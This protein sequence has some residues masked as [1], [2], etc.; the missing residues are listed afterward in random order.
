[1]RPAFPRP[2]DLEIGDTAGLETCGTPVSTK[3]V[4]QTSKSAVSR[5]AKP[6][7][8]P[9]IQCARHF[10]AQPIWKSAIQQ[11][12]K[13]AVRRS[14]PNPY[15]RLPSLP[16]RGLP[17]PLSVCQSNAPGISTSRRFGKRW[18]AE[19]GETENSD[20]TAPRL[21][22]IFCRH[23]GPHLILFP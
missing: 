5:V 15:R 17:N 7:E 10:H 21:P 16:Y 9:S 22:N 12:W 8:R 3:P 14:A 23:P 6:A 18:E 11:V 4:P 13:P 19:D 20:H 2:A 1:M